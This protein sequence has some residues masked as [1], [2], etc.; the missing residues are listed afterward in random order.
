[1][2]FSNDDV[3][4]VYDRTGGSCFY[5]GIRLSFKNYG[6]VG[7]KGAWEIDHF[8]P[9]ASKG[10]HQPYNWVSRH[11]FTAILRRVICSHGNICQIDFGR[12]IE[13]LRIICRQGVCTIRGNNG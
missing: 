3:N 10:A 6:I 9:I 2:D 5:C 12:E 1:M 11:V 7:N 4:W 8:I 13:T